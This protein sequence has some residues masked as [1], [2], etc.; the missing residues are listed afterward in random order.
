MIRWFR[1]RR[2][3]AFSNGL[4]FQ[5]KKSRRR[6]TIIFTAFVDHPEVS[7]RLGFLIGNDPVEF[8]EFE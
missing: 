5:P 7:A 2:A 1:L 6:I 8:S 3:K 4:N